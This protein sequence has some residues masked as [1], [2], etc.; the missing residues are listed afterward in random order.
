MWVLVKEWSRETNM[1]G[2]SDVLNAR[3]WCSRIAWLICIA[4][5]AVAMVGVRNSLPMVLV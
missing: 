3:N 1:H 4:L 2:P 5:F